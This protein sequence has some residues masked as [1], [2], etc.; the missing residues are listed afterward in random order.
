MVGR[1]QVRTQMQWHNYKLGGGALG[2]ITASLGP[3]P[4][5]PANPARG[6]GEPG[7]LIVS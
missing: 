7:V 4:L 3:I 6:P 5:F 2:T 1:C